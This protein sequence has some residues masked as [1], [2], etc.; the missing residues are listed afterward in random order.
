MKSSFYDDLIEDLIRDPNYR[1][2]RNGTI[3]TLRTK[4]GRGLQ[5]HWR[6]TGTN[7][8]NIRTGH[9]CLKYKRKR[10]L[11]HRVIYR[12]FCGPLSNQMEIDHRDNNSKN[13]KP[14]NLQ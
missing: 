8:S 5:D 6:R 2:K 9:Y 10:L 7:S 1:I 3:W 14:K 13:N 4:N 11:V 12:K